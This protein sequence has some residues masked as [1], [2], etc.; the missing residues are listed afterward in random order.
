MDVLDAEAGR[1]N[2]FVGSSTRMWRVRG[3][4]LENYG[5]TSF[6]QSQKF[7]IGEHFAVQRPH[8]IISACVF[9]A[10]ENDITQSDTATDQWKPMEYVTCLQEVKNTI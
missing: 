2:S 6:L 7:R 10:K 9:T 8:P 1:V 4:P 5:M 3:N